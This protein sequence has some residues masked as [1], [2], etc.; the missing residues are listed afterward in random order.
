MTRLKAL[1]EWWRSEDTSRT[2]LASTGFVAA[3]IVI[4]VAV[5]FV[6]KHPGHRVDGVA[7]IIQLLGAL[8]A[9]PVAVRKLLA[10]RARFTAS[11]LAGQR[12]AAA[13]EPGWI[14]RGAFRLAMGNGVRAGL[15]K[16]P[17]ALA[18]G[19]FFSCVALAVD[20]LAAASELI[21]IVLVVLL[22]VGFLFALFGVVAMVLPRRFHAPLSSG[23]EILSPLQL[24]ADERFQGMLA[25]F[26]V[27]LVLGSI[28]LKFLALYA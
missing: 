12:S 5:V 13:S 17:I 9:A 21:V 18:V 4:S 1:A 20:F 24:A 15:R 6:V 7:T 28:M 26:G 8:L 10:P 27:V 11:M 2:S 25:T 14:E 16:W 23:T 22:S 3:G 19:A